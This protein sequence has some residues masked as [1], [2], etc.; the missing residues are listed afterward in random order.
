[1][2]SAND[3]RRAALTLAATLALAT[4][5]AAQFGPRQNPGWW[6]EG[7]DTARAEG[8]REGFERGD[9][10]RRDR[11][12]FN[13]TD[14]RTYRNADRGYR[15]E[16]GDRDTYRR[17]FRGAYV[18]GYRDAYHGGAYVNR[19]AWSRAGYP[20]PFPPYP[21]RYRGSLPQGRYPGYS[22]GIAA[23]RTNGFE[24]GYTKGLEDA[25]DADRFDPT[26]HGWYKSASRGY[27]GPFGSKAFYRDQYRLAFRE[28][29][30]RGFR[31]AQA[32]RTGRGW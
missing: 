32:Y 31:N 6:T 26:R 12:A 19:D 11:R 17:A 5:A 3:W 15:R 10:D 20:G 16:F 28:G 7:Q 13:Y 29:Y 22:I 23:A 9:E 8:Y 24:D 2:G 18:A 1:M 21:N 30:E 4:P 27:R 25:R 14:E